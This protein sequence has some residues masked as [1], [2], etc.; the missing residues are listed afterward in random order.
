M[1]IRQVLALLTGVGVACG[2]AGKVP[3]ERA[4][5]LNGATY[6][7]TGAEKA[8]SPGGVAEFTGKFKGTWPGA[9]PHGWDPGPYKDEKPQFSITAE[10]MAQYANQL[11]EGQKG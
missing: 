3:A 7:C 10:N 9:K 6:T 2:A 8:G 11:T 5:E 1:T 4:A